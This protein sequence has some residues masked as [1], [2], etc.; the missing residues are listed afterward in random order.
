MSHND[1]CCADAPRAITIAGAVALLCLHL[2]STAWLDFELF[3]LSGGIVEDGK[4]T[5]YGGIDW[6]WTSLAWL[7]GS[8]L[9]AASDSFWPPLVLPGFLL[10][11]LGSAIAAYSAATALERIVLA[12]R[13]RFGRW[14]WRLW[15]PVLLWCVWLPVPAAATLAYQ[16]TVLY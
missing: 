15:L 2:V 16:Y 5:H 1:P 12:V 8:L 6:A 7:P 9:I 11:L 10:L 14:G 3:R 4:L 13:P